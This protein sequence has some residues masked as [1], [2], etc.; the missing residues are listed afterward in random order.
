MSGW[1]TANIHTPLQEDKEDVMCHLYAR[2]LA[3]V[4]KQTIINGF[5]KC[6]ISNALDGSQDDK[7]WKNDCMNQSDENMDVD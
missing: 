1:L 3:S 5:L 4:S 6:C 2:A 7:I